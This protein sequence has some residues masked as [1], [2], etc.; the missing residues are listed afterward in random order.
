MI[1]HRTHLQKLRAKLAQMAARG[2]FTITEERH[3]KHHPH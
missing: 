2:Q 3:G 1:H